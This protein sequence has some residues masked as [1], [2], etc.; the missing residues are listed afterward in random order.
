MVGLLGLGISA[1]HDLLEFK[2]WQLWHESP[3]RCSGVNEWRACL[4]QIQ[5]TKIVK[6]SEGQ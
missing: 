6:M 2:S 4:E 5:I 1:G 3:L